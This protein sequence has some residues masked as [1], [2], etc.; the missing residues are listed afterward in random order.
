MLGS[1]WLFV[2][3]VFLILVWLF[4]GPF[5]NY[6]DTWQLV[7]NTATTVVHVYDFTVAGR[8]TS[9]QILTSGTN[10]YAV[11]ESLAS[12][13]ATSG[14]PSIGLSLSG[15]P[16]GA[17]ASFAPASGSAGECR[18]SATSLPGRSPGADPPA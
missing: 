18:V 13:S 3:N 7:V 1:P 17:T 16:A 8:P 12:G 10:T 15:L 5:F 11:T 4:S 2:A 6:S 14:L 9:Q